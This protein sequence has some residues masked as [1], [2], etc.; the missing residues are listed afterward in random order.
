MKDV[1]DILFGNEVTKMVK[2][3][4][5]AAAFGLLF[6]WGYYLMM[7]GCTSTWAEDATAK[8]IDD[9]G[10]RVILGDTCKGSKHMSSHGWHRIGRKM[11]TNSF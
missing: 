7:E 11:A 1:T 10:F 6:K 5:V 8:F 9:N 4:N 2:D 3:G